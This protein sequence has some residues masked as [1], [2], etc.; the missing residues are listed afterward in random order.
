MLSDSHVFGTQN[1]GGCSHGFGPLSSRGSPI[2][3]VYRIKGGH[4][5]RF[6]VLSTGGSQ[7]LYPTGI[8]VATHALTDYFMRNA[9]SLYCHNADFL[10][11]HSLSSHNDR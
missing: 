8:R 3:L 10:F 11:L 1:Y 7:R 4:G 9:Y 5:H 6:D 2:G